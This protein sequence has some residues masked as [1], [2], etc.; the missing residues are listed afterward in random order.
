MTH[1]KRKKELAAEVSESQNET[2]EVKDKTAKIDKLRSDLQ[3]HLKENHLGLRLY[4]QLIQNW[5]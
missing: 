4:V 2:Q 1:F 3:E 5:K